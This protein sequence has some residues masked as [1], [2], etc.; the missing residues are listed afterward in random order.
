MSASTFPTSDDLRPDEAQ[1]AGYVAISR[2]ALAA[3]ALGLASPLI[4]AS[5]LLVVVPLAGIAVAVVALRGIAASRGQLKGAWLATIGLCLAT[6]FLG[7]GITRQFSRQ[8]V[9]IEE[10]ER[11]ASGWLHL[12]REGKLQEAD[13]LMRDGFNRI[14]SEGALAEYYR[15]DREASENLQSLFSGEPLRSIRL[16]GPQGTIRLHSIAGQ[17]RSGTSDDLTLRYDY[18]DGQGSSPQ[19]LWITVSRR[20]DLRHG[21]TDWVVRSAEVQPPRGT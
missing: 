12:V 16:L 21:T 13:Q 17:S 9:L 8:S 19:S 1:L 3:L 6:L 15:S 14:R 11:F 5:P 20:I 18:D 7:W 10:S 4:L 2:S